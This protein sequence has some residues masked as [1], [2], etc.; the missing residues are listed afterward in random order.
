MF[1]FRIKKLLDLQQCYIIMK[2]L[3][4][5]YTSLVLHIHLLFITYLRFK[6]N[7]KKGKNKIIRKRTYLV[8][9]LQKNVSSSKN[10][11]VLVLSK[12]LS[13]I[14]SMRGI[15][16]PPALFFT[17]IKIAFL[18]FCMKI[19]AY[20]WKQLPTKAREM[21]WRFDVRWCFQRLFFCQKLYL[22]LCLSKHSRHVISLFIA[23]S[24]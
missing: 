5:R 21:I 6:I 15:V 9:V 14:Y 23:L 17:Y 13:Y 16:C 22:Y 24:L 10:S 11:V 7:I 3:F 19:F 12:I 4:S 8:C 18:L 1:F 2:D 20:G